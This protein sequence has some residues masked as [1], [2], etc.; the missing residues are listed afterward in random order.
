VARMEKITFLIGNVH[1]LK[2]SFKPIAPIRGELY[3]EIS[4]TTVHVC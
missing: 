3:L 4:L 2:A 1:L